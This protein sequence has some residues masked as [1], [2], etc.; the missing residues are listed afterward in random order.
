MACSGEGTAAEGAHHIGRC[1]LDLS[2]LQNGDAN[3]VRLL[4][5]VSDGADEPAQV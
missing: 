3:S 2:C 1:L 4:V 5:I